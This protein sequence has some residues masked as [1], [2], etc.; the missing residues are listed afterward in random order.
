MSLH[1]RISPHSCNT[2]FVVVISGHFD[3]TW[4]RI[5][6][7]ETRT[8]YEK[9]KYMLGKFYYESRLSK[10]RLML[11]AALCDLISKSIF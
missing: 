9:I 4:G 10:H 11:S 3:E 6:Y 5:T 1:D 2:T 8:D 7:V